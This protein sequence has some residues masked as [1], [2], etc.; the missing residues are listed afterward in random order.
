MSNI[1]VSKIKHI[2][3]DWNGTLLDDLDLCI[4][5]INPM[6]QKRKLK[7]VSRDQ[8]LDIFNFPVRDYYLKIGFDFELELFENVSTE[9]ISA[10]ETGRP[11]CQLM[12]DARETLEII[13]NSRRTQSILSASKSSYLNQAVVDYDIKKYFN[14]INGL[15]NHHAA[16]K[17]S[18]ARSY[19]KTAG[20]N[21]GEVL[22]IGDTIHDAEIADD[23]GVD[24]VLI[25]NGHQNRR[26][27]T[28]A[29]G[30][31]IDRLSDLQDLFQE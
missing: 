15:D 25:P 10:Y 3:W 31:L 30:T 19:M 29:G 24:Y 6:L 20:H 4:S 7:P 27:L 23:I 26:R 22:L 17:V 21:P 5:I 16:G 9:F 2:I 1:Q 28:T 12:D 18:L 8:Y 13:H 11:G 14:A